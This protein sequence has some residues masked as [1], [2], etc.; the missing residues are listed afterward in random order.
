MYVHGEWILLGSGN[1]IS[2]L[3]HVTR[4]VTTNF[5]ASSFFKS[6]PQRSQFFEYWNCRIY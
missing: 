5:N 6:K 4:D 3:M 2:V 1:T